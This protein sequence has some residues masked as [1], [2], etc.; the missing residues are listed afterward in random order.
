[1]IT[2]NPGKNNLLKAGLVLGSVILIVI[3]LEV[4][5]RFTHYSILITKNEEFRYYYM[6]DL[7]KGYDIKPNVSKFQ[8]NVDEKVYFPVWSNALGCFDEPY[9]GEKNYILLLGDSFVHGHAPFADKWG[10]QLQKLLGY[11]VLKCGVDSYGTNQEFLK[12]KEIIKATQTSPHLI[13]LGYCFNDLGDDYLFPNLTVIDGYLVLQNELKDV[14]TGEILP[15]QNLEE[16]FGFFSSGPLIEVKNFVKRHSIIGKLLINSIKNEVMGPKDNNIYNNIFI[17]FLDF[18]WIE[19][20]W[21]NHLKNIELIKSLAVQND[22]NL[23]IVIIPTREQVYPFL[24]DWQG[25]GLD[26]GKPNKKIINFF[27]QG[28]IRYIDLLPLLKECADQTPRKFL[29]PEKDLYWRYDGHWSI[30]GEQLVG[31]LVAKYILENNL[32]SSPDKEEKLISINQK[33]QE[34]PAVNHS[35]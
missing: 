23:L 1:M 17:S 7:N 4:I 15:R 34:F 8:S 14:K 30:K 21:K 5:L 22:A 27:N 31:L 12:G 20:A 35:R 6:A 32:I 3:L 11:R 24:F 25:A 13:I 9:K 19:N 16:K 33:L 26:P 29:S 18:P 28:G 10:S 2:A